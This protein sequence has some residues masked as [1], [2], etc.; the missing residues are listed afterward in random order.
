MALCLC[1]SANKTI[2]LFGRKSSPILTD[3]SKN[4]HVFSFQIA[5]SLFRIILFHEIK[6]GRDPWIYNVKID[7]FETTKSDYD[8]FKAVPVLFSRKNC[9]RRSL[10]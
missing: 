8:T 7:E 6:L 5:L 1:G 4:L 3:F 2:F 10:M 9:W